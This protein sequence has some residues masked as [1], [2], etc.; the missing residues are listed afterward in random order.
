[1]V[2]DKIDINHNLEKTLKDL[3]ALYSKIGGSTG[4]LIDSAEVKLAIKLLSKDGND[5]AR[6]VNRS[7]VI[8]PLN[9]DVKDKLLKMI[10]ELENMENSVA[11]GVYHAELRHIFGDIKNAVKNYEKKKQVSKVDQDGARGT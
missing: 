6:E 10:K 11:L 9:T 2:S 1:M 3:D 5:L 8:M 4:A 7:T